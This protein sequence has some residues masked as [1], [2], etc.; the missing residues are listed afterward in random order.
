[1]SRLKN[2]LTHKKNQNLSLS[3]YTEEQYKTYQY[4]VTMQ[5]QSQIKGS[6]LFTLSRLPCIQMRKGQHNNT[7]AISSTYRHCSK[8]HGLAQDKSFNIVDP[9]KQVT[10]Y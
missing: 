4:N 5:T 1:M 6:F 9:E 2:T 3:Q 10:L 8:H 7:S